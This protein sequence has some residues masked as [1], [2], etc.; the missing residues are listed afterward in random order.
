MEII[1][2]IILALLCG[3]TIG[4]VLAWT[5]E[6]KRLSEDG[7]AP[8]TG[9]GFDAHLWASDYFCD[10]ISKQMIIYQKS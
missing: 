8:P 10:K 1:I 7:F 3:V 4:T 5:K 9:V 2:N 6:I